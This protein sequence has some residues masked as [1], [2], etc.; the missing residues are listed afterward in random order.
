MKWTP[1]LIRVFLI[2]P[3]NVMGTIPALILWISIK[4][5]WFDPYTLNFNPVGAILGGLLILTGAC[6]AWKS[7]S[8][9]TEPGGTPAP[10]NPP[11]G[12]VI[13]GIYAY[14]RNPMVISVFIVLL[15]ESILCGS[16]PL[17]LWA[18]FF[19][20]SAVIFVYLFEEK[21]LRKRFGDAYKQYEKQVPRW[22]PRRKP[23]DGT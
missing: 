22:I 21:D 14:V 8:D 3:L 18:G 6:G 10:W 15:G 12:L 1:E 20:A 17:L 13:R 2:V 11:R 9:L 16:I 4:T 5:G 7:I 19:I 23:W